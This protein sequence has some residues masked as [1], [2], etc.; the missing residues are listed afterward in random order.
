MNRSLPFMGISQCALILL[1]ALFLGLS[2]S[3]EAQSEPFAVLERQDPNWQGLPGFRENA[4]PALYG[5]Y[6]LA[7]VSAI[8]VRVFATRAVLYIAESEWTSARFP[9]V[10]A[11]RIQSLEMDSEA[12]SLILLYRFIEHSGNGANPSLWSVV[13]VIPDTLAV[14]LRDMFL[15]RWVERFKLF[16]INAHSEAEVSLPAILN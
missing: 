7:A 15:Q 16:L 9:V 8:R 1:L 10:G 4:I 5:E 14:S 3:V 2:A 13:F 6:S 12:S 11:G